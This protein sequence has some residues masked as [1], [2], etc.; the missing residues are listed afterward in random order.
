MIFSCRVLHMT[1]N[2]YN[3]Q[4]EYRN[5]L[6]SAEEAVKAV[7]SDDLVIF[8]HA[9]AEP[10]SLVEA[11]VKRR[12][13]HGVRI[14]HMVPV[15]PCEY[16][17]PGMERFFWHNAYFVGKPTRQ[18][19][20]EGRADFTPLF[21][22]ELPRVLEN[23]AVDVTMIQV[24]PPNKW[25]F[26]SLGISLD[27]SQA[28]CQ[29]AKIVIAQVNELM[30]KTYGDTFI[31]IGDIDWLVE[32]S[33]PLLEVPPAEITAVEKTI[34]QYVADLIEDGS[35]LQL[36]IGPIPDAVL[37]ALHGKKDLGIHTEMFSDRLVDLVESGVVTGKRKNLNRD[38]IVCSF[39][40]GTKKLYDFVDDNPMIEFRTVNYTNDPAVIG[41]HDKFVAIN[42]ALE[43]DLLGQVCA[44]TIGY[45]QYSAVG[46]QVDFVRG[47]ARSKG[48]KAIIALPSSAAGGR[49]S[50][51]VP[52][53]KEGAVVTTS[54]YD[55]QYVVTDYGVA[56]LS[57]KTNRERAEA[58]IRVAHPDHREYLRA[59]AKK[60]NLV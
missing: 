58:L 34:A 45:A 19:V 50:R 57:A 56:H 15:G 21:F 4:V 47:A 55:V 22:H 30:P 9:C 23:L 38:K 27:Y 32:S 14:A 39:V 31:H 10:R 35:T 51:I 6:V 53:L 2:L 46:G 44:D 1:N 26:C 13:L 37:L 24:S 43:V 59:N 29:S 40:M 41:Q 3:W 20:N 11:L 36:G 52:C 5:K 18:A 60:R 48:G 12:D 49:I 8:Q 33:R 16:A 54:R 25:G 42:S 7:N 28:A 17:Q